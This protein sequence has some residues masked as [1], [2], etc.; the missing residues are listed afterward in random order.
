M[1]WC[2]R[3]RCLHKR[4]EWM[5]CRSDKDGDTSTTKEG[6]RSQKNKSGGP[7]S[8]GEDLSFVRNAAPHP[9]FPP[10]PIF[11]FQLHCPSLP[12]SRRLIAHCPDIYLQC[13][14]STLSSA[15]VDSRK[16]RNSPLAG[17]DFSCCSRFPDSGMDMDGQ[18]SWP[19]PAIVE[20]WSYL[21]PGFSL[22]SPVFTRW[23]YSAGE[24]CEERTCRTMIGSVGADPRSQLLKHR[25]EHDP[26]HRTAD[27]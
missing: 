10:S 20:F 21:Y 27:R 12:P 11:P 16:M 15:G 19:V 9:F 22:F 17:C 2:G 6:N 24:K 1:G 23:G 7:I 25:W 26:P 3:S 18:L 13:G 8:E 5:S 14:I 4:A